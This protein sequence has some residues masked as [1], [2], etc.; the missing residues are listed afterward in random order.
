MKPT[1][2]L[3]LELYCYTQSIRTPTHLTDLDRA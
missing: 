3:M 2:A 1:N